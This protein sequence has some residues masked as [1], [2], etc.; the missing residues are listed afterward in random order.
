M[1]P[2]PVFLERQLLEQ[3]GVLEEIGEEVLVVFH[4]LRLAAF[5]GVFEVYADQFPEH[6]PVQGV[7]RLGKE[8]P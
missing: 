3:L 6:G 1:F 8:I 4:D 2:E 7:G 5:P